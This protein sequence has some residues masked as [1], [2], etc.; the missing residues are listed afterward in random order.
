M[1]DSKV[2]E[3]QIIE[4]VGVI[5]INNPPVNALTLEVREE[6]KKILMEI[7]Q[8]KD[9]RVLVITGAGSKCF[10]AGADIKDFPKQMEF[11]PRENATIYKEM[12][13]YLEEAPIPVIAALNGLAL[14]G[15]CELALACDLRIADEKVKLGL[16][17]VT[18][19]LIPGLGGTQ[20]LA[21]LIG[22]SKA[23]ELLFTGTVITAEEALKIGLVNQVVPL[24]TALEEALKLAHKLAKG[25]G[26]AMAYAKQLVNKGTELPLQE[27]LEM[28][29]Q[30]VEKIFRTEDL[31]EGLDAFINKRPPVFKNR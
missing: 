15:G 27:A 2:V 3:L 7:R 28:E 12:F 9:L 22:Q 10:V 4:S 30:H 26:V 1:S 6:L 31:Q 25:A 13:A 11:G 20:R 23:K 21:R 24:G 16:P 29:M 5:T 8:A 18:L 19:G 14:G 17:E